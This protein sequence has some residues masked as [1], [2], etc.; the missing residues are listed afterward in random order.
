MEDLWKSQNYGGKKIVWKSHVWLNEENTCWK[1]HEENTIPDAIVHLQISICWCAEID[2]ETSAKP[3]EQW[4]LISPNCEQHFLHY[5]MDLQQLYDAL[6][7]QQQQEIMVLGSRSIISA[8]SSFKFSYQIMYTCKR[9]WE[10]VLACD[11][12]DKFVQL[13]QHFPCSY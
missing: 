8:S 7:Q 11:Y 10:L 2:K 9:I 3:R 12:D 5:A 6:P 13:P 1:I 4:F